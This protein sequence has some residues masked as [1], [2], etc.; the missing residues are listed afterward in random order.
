MKQTKLSVAIKATLLGAS[1][2]LA[3]AAFA[4]DKELLEALLSNGSLSQ[5]Q[6][7]TLMKNAADDITVSTKGG[8]LK[9][10]SGDAKFQIGGRLMADYAAISDDR[11]L[12]GDGSEFRRARLFVKGEVFKDWGF[13]AQYDFAEDEVTAKDLY[14]AYDGFDSTSIKVGNTFMPSGLEA[15]TSSKYITFMERSMIQD[16][17]AVGRKNGVSV[18]TNGDNWTLQG[19]LHMQGVSND[20]NGRDEDY[21]YGVRATFAPIAGQTQAVHFGASFSHQEFDDNG[22]ERFRARPE[23]HT[24]NNR[25]FDTKI[26]GVE[27]TDNY[28]L[29]AAAV[30]GPFS[31][32]TEYFAKEVQTANGDLDLDGWY[33]YG[34]FFLTGESRAY[35]GSKGS[36]GRVKPNSVVGKGGIGAWELGVRYSSIDLYDGA[37][38]PVNSIGEE[39][40]VLTI[41]VNWYATP[42]IRFMANYV[43]STV[44]HTGTL[45]ADEDI[46]ALQVRAQIDF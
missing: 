2:A 6:Y 18:T 19:G 1:I 25:P 8:H 41:G 35:D 3:P 40:E 4:A 24:I 28:G 32:Q 22:T 23:I 7:D 21:G 34:S 42:T 5:G 33:A 29:E 44:E 27:S 31:L 16:V 12:D 26:D 38:A 9:F 36:F 17:F 20:N 11:N 15:Q 10:K 37:L 14:I 30:M 39:G 46:D 45:L 43:Q 13:K